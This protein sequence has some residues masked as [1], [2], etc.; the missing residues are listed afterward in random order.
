MIAKLQG[1]RARPHLID[2]RD[3]IVLMLPVALAAISLPLLV[4]L[5]VR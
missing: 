4:R 5:V 3:A 2:Y 1:D